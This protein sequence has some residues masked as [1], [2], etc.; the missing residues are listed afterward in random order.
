MDLPITMLSVLVEA[1]SDF[2]IALT[3]LSRPLGSCCF[4]TSRY[5]CMFVGDAPSCSSEVRAETKYGWMGRIKM[6]SILKK[7][8][9]I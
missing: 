9:I 3:V 5:C 4:A 6:H 2:D 1:A 7:P 8:M